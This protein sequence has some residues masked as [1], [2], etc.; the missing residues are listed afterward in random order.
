MHYIAHIELPDSS[1]TIRDIRGVVG[2][3]SAYRAAQE[4]LREGE[5][6]RGIEVAPAALDPLHENH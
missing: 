3:Q 2:I 1:Q 5:T 6:L 4:E